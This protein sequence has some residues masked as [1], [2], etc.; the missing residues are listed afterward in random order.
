[1]STDRSG[2][3]ERDAR[4][5]GHELDGFRRKASYLRVVE[6]KRSLDPD[7]SRPPGP[8]L[9]HFPARTQASSG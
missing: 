4:A 7:T 8:R 1:M 5:K 2:C 9:L 3:P 6:P